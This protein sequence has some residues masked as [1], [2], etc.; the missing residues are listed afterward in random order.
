M[1]QGPIAPWG[2]SIQKSE[3]NFTY[4]NGYT[5]IQPMETATNMW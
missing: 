3:H 5:E 2:F 4:F 1:I